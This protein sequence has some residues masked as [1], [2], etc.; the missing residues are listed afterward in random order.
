[1]QLFV[2]HNI[3]DLTPPNLLHF[4]G[5]I[6]LHFTSEHLFL[7]FAAGVGHTWLREFFHL[8]GDKI[9]DKVILIVAENDDELIARCD[10]PPLSNDD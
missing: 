4:L 7:S 1:M 10:V 3:F 2:L 5:N 8:L 6:C 9:G